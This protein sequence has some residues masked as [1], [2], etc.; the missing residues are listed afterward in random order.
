MSKR[1]SIVALGARVRGI[2]ELQLILDR[3]PVLNGAE[4]SIEPLDGGITNRNYRIVVDGQTFVLRIA[5]ERTELLLIDRETEYACSL[6][7]ASAGI[8]AEVI[9]FLPDVRAMVTR[10]V[11]GV[12]GSA[13]RL[14]QTDVLE[15]TVRSIRAYHD[16]PC[17][18]GRFDAFATIERYLQT[19]REHHV[20]FSARMPAA[21]ATLAR[22]QCALPASPMLR[23]CHNDLLSNNLLDDGQRVWII[24]WEYA[25]LGDVFFD[26]ANLAEHHGFTPD[27]ERQLLEVYFGAAADADW[28]RLR[29]MRAVS[30]LRETAWA[31]VQMGVSKLDFD[32]AA[33][34]ETHLAKFHDAVARAGE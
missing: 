24:D 20:E 19:A 31:C 22:I 26:L 13:A 9:A 21:L 16:C 3:V 1:A 18:A 10:F 33:Y 8:G 12:P 6:A 2:V 5:G 14:A 4:R 28:A 29:A 30:S 25:G 17:D 7:A 15:R 11:S 23:P 27:Q 34:A 32:F